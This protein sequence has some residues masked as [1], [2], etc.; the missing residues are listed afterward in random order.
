MY[1]F[2]EWFSP[3]YLTFSRTGLKTC[4]VQT[5]IFLSCHATCAV[6]RTHCQ[7]TSSIENIYCKVLSKDQ[8][9]ADRF[10]ETSSRFERLGSFENWIGWLNI[11]IPSRIFSTTSYFQCLFF[12]L[13]GQDFQFHEFCCGSK[14]WKVGCLSATILAENYVKKNI[15]VNSIAR[16]KQQ[17]WVETRSSLFRPSSCRM[18]LYQVSETVH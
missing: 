11:S 2:F 7:S 15:W 9:A 6:V 1:L 5:L 4:D 18:F 14:P 17:K 16:S 3:L 12:R 10:H 13:F 8:E